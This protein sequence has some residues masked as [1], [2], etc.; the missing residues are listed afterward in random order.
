[1]KKFI[2]LLI[3]SVLLSSAS[4]AQEA[5]SEEASPEETTESAPAETPAVETAPPA[6]ETPTAPAP[7]PART[8]AKVRRKFISSWGV[9]V[10]A[11]Q[12]NDTL[13]LQQGVTTDTDYANYNGLI[14]TVQKEFTYLRWGWAAAG[15]IGSGRANG[16]GNSSTI[17]YQKDMVAF[18]VYG[19]SPRA[20]YRLSGRINAG[21]TGM[22]FMR[23]IDWP[24]DAANQ[25]IDSGRNMNVMALA[26]LNVRLFHK[27]DFYSGIG[28]LKEGSTLWKVGVNY[29]F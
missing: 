9:G 1:M 27:W 16:G 17:T 29:R 21:V 28:P 5:P 14:L 4:F 7:A 2:S 12:W 26:D 24:K 19:V 11:L 3:A 23:S 18:T 10:S 15:F 25:T 6:E 13:K 20:F 22:V 8:R